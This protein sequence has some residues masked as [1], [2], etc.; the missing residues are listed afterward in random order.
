MARYLGPKCKLSRREGT[1]LFLKSGIKPI[2]SK[3]KLNSIPG[4]KIG[5]RRERLSDYGNQLREKQKLRRM[6]GVMEKQFRNYYKKASK[7]KGSTGENL[8]KLLEGRLDN[9]VYRMGFAVTRAEARQLVTH[10]SIMINGKVINIPS[11]QVNASDEISVTDKAKEQLRVKNAVNISSQLGISE[12]LS[13]DEKKLK[14][15]V[16]SIPER[17]DILPDIQENLVVEF[18]SK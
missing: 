15:I 16:N 14:G 18:Y 3:C 2:E 11:Y 12:W 8:L 7:I 6:Y 1:D 10:K 4:S 17:E 5:S 13:V 9:M